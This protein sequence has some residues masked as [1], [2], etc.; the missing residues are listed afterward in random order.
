V[1]HFVRSQSGL[2]NALIDI[3]DAV[4]RL[5][6]LYEDRHWLA[7]KSEAA[8]RFAA[9]YDWKRIVLQ[10]HTLL[11]REVP[12]LRR[13]ARSRTGNTLRAEMLR[14]ASRLSHT[15]T[16]P[17]TLPPAAPPLA[18]GRLLGYV[19]A[20]SPADVGVLRVL[21]RIFPGLQVWSSVALEVDSGSMPSTPLHATVVPADSPTYRANLAASTLA[22]DLGGANPTLPAESADLAVPCIGL[23]RQA[24]QVRLWPELSLESPDPTA[25][26]TLAR[27]MLTDQG[28]AAEACMRARQ[29]LTGSR[30]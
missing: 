8:Q 11:E 18:N 6:R 4:S 27:W 21:R 1:K 13:T 9:S 29:R 2:R 24:D 28:D 16:L 12:H 7:S 10:W 26:A 20:A 5:Q 30:L 25:A 23:T 15:L 19:Y 14:E 3:D 22:L 17:V